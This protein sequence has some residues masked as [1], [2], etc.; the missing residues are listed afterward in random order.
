[1]NFFQKM[2]RYNDVFEIIKKLLFLGFFGL[3]SLYENSMILFLLGLLSVSF[4]IIYNLIM[5]GYSVR[6]KHYDFRV[7]SEHETP[8]Q[9]MRAL[10]DKQLLRGFITIAAF[11]LCL[12]TIAAM[13]NFNDMIIKN[14]FSFWTTIIVLGLGI[15]FVQAISYYFKQLIKS[16]KSK[17][18]TDNDKKTILDEFRI[19]KSV[20]KEI[21]YLS[22]EHYLIG[23]VYNDFLFVKENIVY[24]KNKKIQGSS[25]FKYLIENHLFVDDMTDQD[26]LVYTMSNT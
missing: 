6:Y 18:I 11:F 24:Y 23:V 3:L 4:G 9:L 2:I 21:S 26:M 16:I 10:L 22:T 13:H 8:F 14:E 19:R 7:H 12:Y 15:V 1:M 25:F 5:L 17:K 20:F